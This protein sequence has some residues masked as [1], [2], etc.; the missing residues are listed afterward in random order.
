MNYTP[1][2]K[3][4]GIIL[5]LLTAILLFAQPAAAM[6]DMN[7]KATSIQNMVGKGKWT[8]VKVWASDCHAC[9]QTIHYL[10]QFEKQF[11]DASVFGISIDG[12]QGKQN[13]QRF[14]DQFKL[15]FPNLLSDT[16]E[17]DDYLYAS[18]GETLVGTPT[19]I[20]YNP[21]GKIAAVQPGAVKPDDLIRFIRQK[22]AETAAAN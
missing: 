13:A 4:T 21:Q 19:I 12:Q 5:A 9:R 15:G 22:Q 20:V 14:I 10:A 6:T 1:H 3:N 18:V 17:I 2:L 16:R 11:T 7:G 8:V